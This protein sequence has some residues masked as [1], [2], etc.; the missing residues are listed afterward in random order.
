MPRTCRPPFDQVRVAS[1]SSSVSSSISTPVDS[2]DPIPDCRSGAPPPNPHDL[3]VIHARRSS[4]AAT[5]AA[6]SRWW[7]LKEN[8]ARGRGGFSRRSELPAMVQQFVGIA[9]SSSRMRTA[10][11][12]GVGRLLRRPPPPAR[13]ESPAGAPSSRDPPD[14]PPPTE[15]RGCRL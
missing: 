1:S 13:P 3:P 5:L 2:I 6:S 7:Q 11:R 12:L 8:R 15:D 14:R 10:P 9:A 4:V